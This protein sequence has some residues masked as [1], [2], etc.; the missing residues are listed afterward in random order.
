MHFESLDFAF[1]FLVFAYGALITTILSLPLF[2]DLAETRLPNAVSTQ[3][4]SHRGLGWFCLVTGALW[5]LQNL[6][7]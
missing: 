1:P 7:L 3:L 5:S 2:D 6:W 4:K